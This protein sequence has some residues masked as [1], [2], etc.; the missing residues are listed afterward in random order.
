MLFTLHMTNGD[1]TATA[2]DQNPTYTRFLHS[3]KFSV[4]GEVYR[5]EGRKARVWIS[6]SAEERATE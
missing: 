5:L 2:R 4:G 3:S 6:G 1:V